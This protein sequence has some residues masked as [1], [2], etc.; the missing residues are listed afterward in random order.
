MEGD[1]QTCKG[2]PAKAGSAP[3]RP[4][5]GFSLHR[6]RP[7]SLR[8]LRASKKALLH[9]Y[10]GLDG[11]PS[12][13][14]HTLNG[15]YC[16]LLFSGPRLLAEGQLGARTNPQNP[17]HSGKPLGQRFHTA[18]FGSKEGWV[19]GFWHSLRKLG[20]GRNKNLGLGLLCQ[21]VP[22]GYHLA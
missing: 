22:K 8:R 11:R 5:A 18:S 15:V 17:D 9:A 19:G 2:R 3:G 13:N 6:N 7:L 16:V 10:Q 12:N 4:G 14:K 20:E 1:L 21:E